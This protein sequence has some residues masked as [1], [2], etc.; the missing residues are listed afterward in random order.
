M[1]LRV[2]A[3]HLQVEQLGGKG[4]RY[5]YRPLKMH[6]SIMVSKICVGITTTNYFIYFKSKFKVTCKNETLN[7]DVLKLIPLKKY[8]FCA[9]LVAILLF[10]SSKFFN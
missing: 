4:R 3:L 7:A 2:M 1:Y 10:F 6:Y 9:I 8:K 5:N